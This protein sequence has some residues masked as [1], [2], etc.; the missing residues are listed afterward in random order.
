MFFSSSPGPA[1]W[2]GAFTLLELM[3]VLA[4][5]GILVTLLIPV[6]AHL[7]ERAQKVQCMANLR[8]LYVGADLYIQREGHWP[9]I[10]IR[11]YSSEEAYANAWVTAL[12]PF[13]IERKTWI[14]P[15]IEL[16]LHN[17]DYQDAAHAR[18][19]YVATSF[20]ETATSPHRWPRQPWF[21]ETG[22]VHG[23]G[24]LLIFTD[25]SIAETRDLRTR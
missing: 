22:D 6:Y 1:R 20:D 9:Q 19:D 12:A 17:P 18:L 24:N 3:I 8:S 4:I 14:C 10:R 11:D 23:N 7:R 13:G 15:T 16:L 2:R 5:I 25:G 21:I